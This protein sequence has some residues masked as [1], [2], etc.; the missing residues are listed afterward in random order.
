MLNSMK[1]FRN[2]LLL[3][4]TAWGATQ[5]QPVGKG[6]TYLLPN[7]FVG[8][9]VVAFGRPMG[10]PTEYH[11]GVRVYRIPAGGV[12]RTQEGATYGL[13]EPDRYFYVNS[14]GDVVKSLPYHSTA[15]EES[16]TFLPTDTICFN[17]IPFKNDNGLHHYV[18]VIV[19]SK[20]QSDSLYEVRDK[21]ITHIH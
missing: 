6:A 12:L 2:T 14:Q 9:V 7:R 4:L 13:H 20:A 8:V 17:A 5:C 1:R 10:A 11:D 15:G 18:G 16:V 3:V 21:V 19:G